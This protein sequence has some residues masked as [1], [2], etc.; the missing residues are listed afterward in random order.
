MDFLPYF[1]N[2]QSV[3]WGQPLDQDYFLSDNI[4][5]DGT[6]LNFSDHPHSEQLGP[7]DYIQ[8]A[9]TLVGINGPV[10][11]T[12]SSKPLANFVWS[13]NNRIASARIG[14]LA[15]V[16]DSGLP[17][18]FS[19]GGILNVQIVSTED[20]PAEARAVLVQ[21]GVQGVPTAPKVDKDAPTTV[22]SFSG[23]LGANG[24]YN[25]PV[26]V[27]L[28]PT[29]IDGP[30]DI[31]ATSY[32][33]DGVPAMTYYIPF[34]VSGDGIHTVQFRSVDQAGNVETV[35]SMTFM[36]DS[37]SP[38]IT[39]GRTP[40][41]NGSD[42]N[43]SAV[44]VT[45]QCS[46]ALSGLAT[47]SPPAPVTVSTQG[48]GQS[49][50]GTCADL[51]GN[52]ASLTVPDIN[53][54][55]TP[56]I[57]GNMPSD[58][59][60]QATGPTGATV[61]YPSPIAT[62]N[63]DPHP[64][65]S[66][67]PASGLFAVGDTSVTCSATDA[68]GNSSSASFTV[69]VQPP[70]LDTFDRPNGGLGSNWCGSVGGYRVRNHAV[71]VN[72]GGPI[73]WC[74]GGS[75]SYFGV[76]QE[77]YVTITSVDW[78]GF[79]QDVLL[80]VQAG[81]TPNYRRGEIEVLYDANN[82]AARVDTLLPGGADWTQYADV[83]LTLQDGDRFGARALSNGE[84]WIYVNEQLISKITL[85]PDDQAFFNSRGGYAGLW[86]DNATAARI[87][88]FSAGTVTAPSGTAR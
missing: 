59:T 67:T 44:A 40:A 11:S 41:A 17:A 34:Q 31:T 50:T 56:P 8:F 35:K 29:D 23:K 1:W 55:F 47:G 77:A 86:F 75:A 10:G 70:V 83:P 49:V 12:S 85:N 62:D 87:D 28:I 88:D 25:G 21:A 61:N 79:E 64:A 15:S 6:A 33:V 24:W 26:T 68:A 51:A 14:S 69:H 80:K 9:T 66:C 60:V 46:D 76:D 57:L 4:S 2:E 45:F 3:A 52:T 36:I 20:L 48:A 19:T 27:T 32:S 74:Q 71:N 72:E 54:D 5:P 38:T 39:D 16:A 78:A 65:L 43:N 73:Y 84:V 18:D 42:W 58:I 63:L 22:T 81:S 7:S 13:S 53:I 82:H 30:A 37:T